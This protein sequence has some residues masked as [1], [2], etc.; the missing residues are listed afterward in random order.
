VLSP[1]DRRC[2]QPIDERCERFVWTTES[3]PL[4][5]DLAHSNDKLSFLS[6]LIGDA[7]FVIENK[8]IFFL[9][10]ARGCHP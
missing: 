2:H 5:S 3:D 8:N 6:G 7:L 10:L 1:P 9:R 4:P